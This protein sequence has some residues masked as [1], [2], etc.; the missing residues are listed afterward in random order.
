MPA[1]A[2]IDPGT[3]SYVLQAIVAAVAG[4]LVAIR[5]YWQKIK[6]AISGRGGDSS[7]ASHSSPHSDSSA[8]SADAAD[9]ASR[10]S[11]DS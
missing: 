3:G 7:S 4:S 1:S 10:D 2:Y 6:S 11:Q 8:E 5:M 9:S